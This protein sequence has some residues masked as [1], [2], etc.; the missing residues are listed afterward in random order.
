[1]SEDGTGSTGVMY[2]SWFGITFG[3]LL[4]IA[5]LIGLSVLASPIIAV[6]IVVLVVGVIAGLLVLGRGR[7]AAEGGQGGPRGRAPYA[8]GP[9]PAPR[10]GGEPVSGEGHASGGE[11]AG[12]RTSTRN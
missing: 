11:T 12:Q 4:L 6:I 5:A 9:A 7:Q 2:G 10:S 3:G 8:G 1:M